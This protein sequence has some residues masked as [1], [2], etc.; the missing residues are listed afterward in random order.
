MNKKTYT[1]EEI[2]ELKAWFDAHQEVIPQDML[3]EEST[4]TPDLKETIQRLFE[5][6]YIY[7]E[8]PKMQGCIVLLRKIKAKIEKGQL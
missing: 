3:I 5:Q 7:C 2:D 1:P 4:Y 6:S 8:N